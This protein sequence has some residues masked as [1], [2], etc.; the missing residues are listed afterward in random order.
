M[1]EEDK[2]RS[3]VAARNSRVA[4]ERV[5]ATR[6]ELLLRLVHLETV[7]NSQSVQIAHLQQKYNLLISKNFN[8]GSTAH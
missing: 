2:F 1:S 6:D 4:V 3:E 8:G 5:Q 7:V